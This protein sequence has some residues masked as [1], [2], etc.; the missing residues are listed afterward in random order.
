[1]YTPKFK[2]LSKY[3]MWFL[4]ASILMAGC[5]SMTK[6]VET[7]TTY[8]P[9]VQVKINI[10]WAKPTTGSP[11]VRYVL[12]DSISTRRFK[13]VSEPSDTFTSVSVATGVVHV[14]RVAGRD[15]QG[16]QGVWS[17]HSDPFLFVPSDD[18]VPAIALE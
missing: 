10:K 13:T 6:P 14:F 4:C 12:Q 3:R 7:T 11:V 16:H 9:P 18:R 5:I 17:E 1:V 2:S 15:S 8:K